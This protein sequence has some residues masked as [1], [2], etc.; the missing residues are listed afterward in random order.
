MSGV[1]HLLR[2]AHAG[3]VLAREGVL[4]LVDPAAVPPGPRLLLRLARTIE[5]R[6]AGTGAARLATALT[7]LGPSYV[8]LGQFLATRPD[9][10]GAAIARDLETLQD[11][12]PPFS[13]A[14]A[15]AAVEEGLG[16]PVAQLFE[17]FGPAIAAASIAQVHRAEIKNADGGT[18]AV[19]VKVLRPNIEHRFQRDLDSFLF[20]ARLAERHSVEARRLRLVSVVETLARSVSI[21]M[22][23]RLEAAA[24]SELA[25]NTKEIGRAHV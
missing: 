12:M 9:V 25:E 18:S 19:A 5:R 6:N 21:E 10:V 20:V 14:E 3:L 23:L 16:K 24:F 15:E 8:K 22:D 17:Q 1:F 13:Q 4:A 11:R 2:L 7:R